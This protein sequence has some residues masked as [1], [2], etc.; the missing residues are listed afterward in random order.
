MRYLKTVSKIVMQ[1]EV[2]IAWSS[3]LYFVSEK[4][5]APRHRQAAPEVVDELCHA[6]PLY[7]CADTFRVS[8]S[9]ADGLANSEES[10]NGLDSD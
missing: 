3:S 8:C 9:E 7:L 5:L 1:R 2:L 4:Q 10:H 6:P